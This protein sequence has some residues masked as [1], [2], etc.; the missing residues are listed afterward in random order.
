MVHR[1]ESCRCRVPDTTTRAHGQLF[2]GD[3]LARDPQSRDPR[4][5]VIPGVFNVDAALLSDSIRKLATVDAEIACFGHGEPVTPQ[6]S[7]L[8]RAVTETAGF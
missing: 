4:T 6:A 2:T 8:I 1:R 7:T 5:P 3:T